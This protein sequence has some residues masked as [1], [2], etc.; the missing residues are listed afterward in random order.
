MTDPGNPQGG[1]PQYQ[2]QPQYQ[3]PQY[4]Q[5]QYQQPQYQQ[6]QYQQYPPQ[7]GY[8][9]P[10]NQIVLPEG[11]ALAE[12]GT[13]L[14]GFLLDI[15][16]MVVTLGIGWMIWSLIAWGGGQ[17]PAK[18]I[19]KMRCVNP[20]TGMPAT[21]GTMFLREFVGRYL[22]FGLIGGLT[23]G[24]GSFVLTF[25]LLWDKKHQQLWD[26]VASTVVVSDPGG[27]YG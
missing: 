23:F 17:T 24:I 19:L 4:Q 8:G 13:R 3:Q 25:M 15:V 11:I 16:L 14:G 1:P 27:I 2:Q 9:Q 20:R 7:Q 22:L 21:W 10:V 18:Q 5:P 26:K 6:P 12:V